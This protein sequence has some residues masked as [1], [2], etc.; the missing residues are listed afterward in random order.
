MKILTIILVVFTIGA[1]ASVFAKN[2]SVL[3]AVGD[4]APNFSLKD[5]NGKVR[6]LSDYS[7]QRLVVY[8]FPKADTPGWTKEAC[9]FRDIYGEYK[10]AKIVVLGISYDSPRALKAFKRKYALP[11]DF[12]SDQKKEVAPK[13]GDASLAWPKRMTFIIDKNGKIEKIYS[14]MNVNTHAEKILDDLLGK[15]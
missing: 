8:F 1:I 14:K 10:R 3:L 9:G 2:Q 12:L 11:F 13:Y 7:G 15:K 5:Q 4:K 6:K